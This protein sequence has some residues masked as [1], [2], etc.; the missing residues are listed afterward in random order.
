MG[1][2]RP[3]WDYIEGKGGVLDP[4]CPLYTDKKVMW[5][6][7]RATYG[8]IVA[9]LLD[10]KS[11]RRWPACPLLAVLSFLGGI[12][13]FKKSVPPLRT[14]QDIMHHHHMICCNQTSGICLPRSVSDTILTV[15][16]DLY[17]QIIM[18]CRVAFVALLLYI[19]TCMHLC[20]IHTLV[21]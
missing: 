10:G 7:L 13:T 21:P 14:M 19:I 3:F 6:T 18:I 20:I 17:I 2:N 4:D 11:R 8:H 9:K 1:L 12:D 16:S 15:I 5:V